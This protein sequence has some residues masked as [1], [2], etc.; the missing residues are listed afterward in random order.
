MN[1]EVTTGI[2]L[3]TV[4]YKENDQ[5]IYVFTKDFGK[6]TLVAKGVKNIKSKNMAALQEM[7]LSEFTFIPKKGVCRLIRATI[8]DSYLFIKESLTLQIYASY[9]NEYIYKQ[10]NDNQPDEHIYKMMIESYNKLKI[11]YPVKLIYSLFNV[12]ML[13]HAGNKI[14]VN[15]CVKCSSTKDIISIGVYDGG[16]I[17]KQC[18]NDHLLYL[19]KILKLFR[20]I[21]LIPIEKIDMIKYDEKDL[22]VVSGLIVEFVE[23]YSGHYFNT[24]KFM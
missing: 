15:Q 11:G 2:V 24:K 4:S 3:K 19:P 5:L 20:H 6:I 17:C 12:F 22:D 14:E 8:K 13:K 7:T 21:Y 1:E 18:C 10:C 16:F 23:E 9:I